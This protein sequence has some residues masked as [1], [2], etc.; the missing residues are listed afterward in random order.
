MKQ[1]TQDREPLEKFVDQLC[2]Q[3]PLRKAPVDL[4]SRVMREVK[5]R[6]ALPWWRKSFLHWPLAMQILFVAAALLTAKLSLTCIHWI[7]ESWFSSSGVLKNSSSLLKGADTVV[8][9]S[10]NVSSYL[11]GALPVS[12]LYGGAALIAVLYLVLFGIGVTT[13]KTLYAT[14]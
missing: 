12:W 10:N 7:S 11:T 5:I 13:Y 6:K 1:D 2:K 14:R 8:A 3:Q 9:V 4:Y